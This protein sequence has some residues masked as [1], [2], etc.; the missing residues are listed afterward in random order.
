MKKGILKSACVILAAVSSMAMFTGCNKKL[1]PDFACTASDYI[2]LGEYKGV[3]AS[4]DAAAIAKKYVDERIRNDIKGNTTYSMTSRAAQNADKVT[5]SY[6]GSIGGT[7]VT[8]FTNTAY[9]MTLGSD[10]SEIQGFVEAFYGMKA[11]ETKVVTATI[12]ATYSDEKYA[13]KKIVFDVA[14]IAVQAPIV[15]QITDTFVKSKYSYSTVEEYKAGIQAEKQDEIDAEVKS[16]RYEAVIDA[17]VKNTEIISYPEDVVNA[18]I[19]SLNTSFATYAKTKKI[20]VEEYCQQTYEMSIE[21]YAKKSVIQD[22]VLQ[23]VI[24]K[25]NLTIDEYYYK[26]NL[27]ALAKEKGYTDTATFVES[28]GKDAIVKSMIIQKAVDV[29]M[30]SANF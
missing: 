5:V 18:K 3:T 16:K 8:D 29:I 27:D 7:N 15:P 19:S 13:G 6:K 11:G 22:L 12:P 25:E 1:N 10:V 17:I 14:V 20:S 24:K 4:V 30:N 21:E 9:S 26:A 23:E 28:I 2:K